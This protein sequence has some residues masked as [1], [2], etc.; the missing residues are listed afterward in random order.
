[1]NLTMFTLRYPRINRNAIITLAVISPL[2]IIRFSY[3][4]LHGYTIVFRKI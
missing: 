4:N 2:G 1:M 3:L